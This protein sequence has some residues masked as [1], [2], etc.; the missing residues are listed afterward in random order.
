MTEWAP[1]AALRRALVVAAVGLVLAVAFGG[2]VLVVLA[3]PF[4][5]L[6]GLGL[7]HRPRQVPTVH[8]TI[9]HPV[10]HEGQG[11]VVSLLLEGAD[12]L[13][14][15]TRVAAQAPY[16]ALQPAG[17]AVSGLLRAGTGPDVRLSPRRWGQVELGEERVGLTTR[18]GGF[19]WGPVLVSGRPMAVL[20]VTAP[21]DSRAEAPQPLGLVGAY[22][23]RRVGSGTEFSGIRPF[24]AGDR[25][26]RVNWRVSLRSREL[27]V[28]DALAET[29]TGVL[30]V[31]DALGEV[32][33]SG[34]IDGTASSLDLTVRAAAALAE[35]H[36]RTGDRVGL[37]VVGGNGALVGYGAGTRHLRVLLG[38]LAA[39]RP[40]VP[41][42]LPDGGLALRAAAGTEVLILSPLLQ[43]VMVT[44]AALLTGRGLPVTVIDT[45][46]D[47]VDVETTDGPSP[48]LVRL[49][50]RLRRAERDLLLER[51][52]HTGCPVVRWRGPGTL[53]DVLRRLARRAQLP[54]VRA[55]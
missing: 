55:R 30:L 9:A 43:P 2:P 17:G 8:T 4:A 18:W 49:A 21:F 12:D 33:R 25:L 36:V 15:V 38:A 34:G 13:E 22:R 47:D 39:V 53:D 11:T 40:G 29:D 10:L 51:L 48:D 50:M 44:T 27:H 45:L 16:V 6:G 26:R 19:R 3:A 42:D 24:V 41:R 52:A 1:T 31:V 35:H 20:P 14:Q 32:G 23:S 54:V 37:R 5:L 46:P 28:V 7:V